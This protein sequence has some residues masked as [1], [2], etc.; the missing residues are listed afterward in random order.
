MYHKTN[1]Q[2]HFQPQISRYPTQPNVCTTQDKYANTQIHSQP[3][4]SHYPT[5][6]PSLTYIQVLSE[7]NKLIHNVKYIAS[8]ENFNVLFE[9]KGVQNDKS[10]HGLANCELNVNP[11]LQIMDMVFPFPKTAETTSS[12]RQ[13]AVVGT[14]RLVPLLLPPPLPH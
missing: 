12:G 8:Q 13:K 5:P 14:R 7:K 10:R 2:I 4:I 3:P 9:G 11:F 6:P 1:T